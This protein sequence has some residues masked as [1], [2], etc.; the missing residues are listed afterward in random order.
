M[1]LYVWN[2][3]HGDIETKVFLLIGMI[4]LSSPIASPCRSHIGTVFNKDSFMNPSSVHV[5]RAT[6]YIPAKKTNDCHDCPLSRWKTET[7]NDD[8]ERLQQ[9]QA[10]SFCVSREGEEEQVHQRGAFH[11]PF[12]SCFPTGTAE[13]MI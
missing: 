2:Y 13:A 9:S 11:L 7:F 1:G 6:K 5:S 10:G 12:C 4:L 3:L 8:R